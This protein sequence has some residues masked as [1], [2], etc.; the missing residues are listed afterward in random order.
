MYL[1]FLFFFFLLLS[2]SQSR[3]LPTPSLIVSEAAVGET[4]KVFQ[5]I[6]SAIQTIETDSEKPLMSL[7]YS[8]K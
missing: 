2:Y 7:F 6:V 8:I 1:F 3:L 5:S 4:T